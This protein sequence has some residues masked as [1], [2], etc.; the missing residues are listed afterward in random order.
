MGEVL[1]SSRFWIALVICGGAIALAILNRISGEL[2]I[3]T[4]SGLMIG[5]GVGKAGSSGKL[6]ALIAAGV[7]A[8]LANVGNR[9]AIRELVAVPD[10]APS[11]AEGTP[12]G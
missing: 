10:A 2:A 8:G 7:R 3:G 4:M 1:R 12:D 11:T 5:F 9:A 6:D